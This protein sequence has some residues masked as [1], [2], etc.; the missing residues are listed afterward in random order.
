[1]GEGSNQPDEGDCPSGMFD[2]WRDVVTECD[3]GRAQLLAMKIATTPSETIVCIA[4]KAALL[5][6]LTEAERMPDDEPEKH[7]IL[8]IARE[9]LA[10]SVQDAPA[11]TNISAV[12]NKSSRRADQ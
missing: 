9:T 1:M 4:A 2:W 11:E 5:A 3:Y 6:L 12:C 10:L 7:L 8:S